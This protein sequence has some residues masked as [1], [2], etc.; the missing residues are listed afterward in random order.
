VVDVRGKRR[1]Q[2]DSVSIGSDDRDAEG[3]RDR[4]V[5]V[6]VTLGVGEA[7][8]GRIVASGALT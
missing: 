4:D 1:A 2:L 3:A 7:R 5:L 6:Q 8:H